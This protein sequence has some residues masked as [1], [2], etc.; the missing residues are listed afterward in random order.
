[1]CNNLLLCVWPSPAKIIPSSP[2]ACLQWLFKI[3]VWNSRNIVRAWH[4]NQHCCQRKRE[5]HTRCDSMVFHIW[6]SSFALYDDNDPLAWQ[7]VLLGSSNV[8]YSFMKMPLFLPFRGLPTYY[9]PLASQLMNLWLQWMIDP[10]LLVVPKEQ[11]YCSKVASRGCTWWR[12]LWHHVGTR[13]AQILN[14]QNQ[15]FSTPSRT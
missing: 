1:M 10:S 4:N 15:T 5:R 3:L 12:S 2:I 11:A 9:N 13:G 8:H 7:T 6:K 14:C